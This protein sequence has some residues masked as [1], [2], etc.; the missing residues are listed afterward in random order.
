MPVRDV[1]LRDGSTLRL[2]E[3]RTEDGPAL[4][5]FF[6]G[7]SAESLRSRFRGVPSLDDSMADRFL[8]GDGVERG[9]LIGEIADRVVALG[10]FE[11]LRNPSV[12]EVAFAVDDPLQGRGV[13]TRLL[14]QLA[15]MAGTAEIDQFVA[16][17]DPRNG[18]MLAVF[19]DAGFDVDSRVEDGTAKVRFAI[20]PTE[21]YTERVEERDHIATV[22]S[23]RPFFQPKSVAV[24]GASRRRGTVGNSLFRNLLDA[25]FQGAVYPVNLGG[26]AVAGVRSYGSVGEIPEPVDLA[27]ICVPAIAA[28]DAAREALAHGVRALCVVSAGFAETGSEGAEREELLLGLVRSAGA[29]MLGPNCLGISVAAANLNATFAPRSFPLG[30]IG[31]SSQSGALG[32]ALLETA[33][34]RGVGLSAFVSVGNKA[35]ISTNDLLEYWEDDPDTGL[36]LLYVESFGNPRKFA[37][38]ARRVARRKP[39]L[40][41]K[42]GTSRA[43]ARAASSH[44]AALAGSETAVDALFHEAGVLRAGTLDELLDVSVLLVNQPPP[45]GNR[46]G[47]LT[48]AGGLGILCADAC[49]AWGLELP[50]LSEAGRGRLK[51]LLPAEGSVANP[52]DLLGSATA[53][54][55]GEA[56]PVMLDD[57]AVDAVIVLFAPAAVASAADVAKAVREAAADATRPVLAVVMSE[58]GIP[59]ELTSSDA[60]VAGFA[61]PESAARALGRAVQRSTWLQRPAGVNRRPGGIDRDAGRTVAKAALETGGGWLEPEVVRALL[62]AYGLPVVPEE[63]ADDAYQAV[64]AARRLGMPAVVKLAGAGLHKTERGGVVLDLRDEE[65][66]RAAAERLGSAV[67]V[68][69]MLHGGVELLLGIVQDPVFGPLVGFGPGGVMAELIGEAAFRIAPLT[70]IDTRELVR[71][72]KAGQLIAGFRGAEPADAAVLED[73]LLRLSAIGEDLPEVAELDL[74]PLIARPDGAVIVDSRARI[75]LPPHVRSSPKTW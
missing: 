41:L 22:A 40:A 20:A 9:A 69:P 16:E 72:G 66:V 67:I 73:I 10:S 48:N 63:V 31:F 29:R 49:E 53:S 62:Q 28:L 45:A 57:P 60:P 15:Q 68:Q 14:E 32:L 7:L 65:A 24:V 27:V 50:R 51:E 54:A 39:V 33:M 34:T 30:K 23:L 43:G 71:Q 59:P 11:R 12:A 42:S 36:V 58:V 21:L 1:I 70:D 44:T 8:N 25:D 37:R 4:L 55:Y 38:V 52:V 64:E 46:V 19:R 17:T 3:P 26:N 35:D 6:A 74:N 56:L 47:V 2:R 75:A 18:P 5:A 13:G 61:Y